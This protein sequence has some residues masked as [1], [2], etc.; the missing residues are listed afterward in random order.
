MLP[1]VGNGVPGHV[2][3]SLW[4]NR[5]GGNHIQYA[6]TIPFP[7]QKD[8]VPVLPPETA[9]M[10][11]VTNMLAFYRGSR[12]RYRIGRWNDDLLESGLI[13]NVFTRGIKNDEDLSHVPGLVPSAIVTPGNDKSLACAGFF[14]GNGFAVFNC[15]FAFGSSLWFITASI[16]ASPSRPP[17]PTRIC[18]WEHRLSLH[19]SVSQIT[20]LE[21]HR[22]GR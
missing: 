9:V 22:H 20:A 18:A 6:E 21:N 2:R 7:S 4:V 10:V 11:F 19:N 3:L 14:H 17:S 13:R 16:H 1:P 12:L 8:R 15:C 5:P